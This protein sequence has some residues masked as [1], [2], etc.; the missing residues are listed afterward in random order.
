MSQFVLHRLRLRVST[1][2]GFAV[3]VVFHG[4]VRGWHGRGKRQKE[5]TATE[6]DNLLQSADMLHRSS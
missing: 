6:L 5:E 2:R 3:S 1:F 4:G